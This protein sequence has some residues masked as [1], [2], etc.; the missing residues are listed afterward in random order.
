MVAVT[1]ARAVSPPMHSKNISIKTGT[2]EI[3]VIKGRPNISVCHFIL[4][5]W[6]LAD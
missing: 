2:R 1:L 4:S 5:S 6:S 3:N